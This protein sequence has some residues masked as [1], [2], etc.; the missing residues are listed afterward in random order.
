MNFANFYRKCFLSLQ[1]LILVLVFKLFTDT[2][3]GRA[4]LI[5]ILA[6]HCDKNGILMVF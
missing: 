1:R 5:L 2:G 6:S 4:I 3:S